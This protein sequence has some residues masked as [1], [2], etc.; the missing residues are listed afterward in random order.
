MMIPG[1]IQSF[2]AGLLISLSG[3]LPLGVL[4][5]SA[6]HIAAVSRQDAV[7]FSIGVILVEMGYVAIIVLLAQS[8]HVTDTLLLLFHIIAAIVL[9]ALA[10]GSFRASASV[11]GRNVILDSH[12]NRM[13]LG[14]SMSL[15]NPLQIPFWMGWI[16]WLTTR[17]LIVPTPA[18]NAVLV[19]GIGTGTF[20]AMLLFIF[21]GVK[22]SSFMQ[23]SHKKVQLFMGVAFSFMALLTIIKLIN[24]GKP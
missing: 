3:S 21:A 8:L 2:F 4:N 10:A 11:T 20:A 5:I 16:A 13:L 18:G 6:M 22:L 24:P 15:T 12:M 19:A 23:R 7:R 14:A 9:L 1:Y 17:A